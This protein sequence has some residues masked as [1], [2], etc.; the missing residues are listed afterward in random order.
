ME[1]ATGLFVTSLLKTGN[2][3]L[4]VFLKNLFTVV[5]NIFLMLGFELNCHC[6][7]HTGFVAYNTMLSIFFSCYQSCFKLVK[8]QRD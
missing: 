3:E 4:D 5:L 8:S 1:W 2:Y 7:I 6:R